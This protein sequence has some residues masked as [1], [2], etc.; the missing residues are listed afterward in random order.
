MIVARHKK[1]RVFMLIIA[2]VMFAATL[3]IGALL[4]GGLKVLAADEIH[5]TH[6]VSFDKGGG[7]GTAEDKIVTRGE[8]YGELP[9][10]TKDGYTFAG[11][12]TLDN[13]RVGAWTEV[14]ATE[15]HFLY[16]KWIP[17]SATGYLFTLSFDRRGGTGTAED[18]IIVFGEAYGTLPVVTKERDTFDGWYTKNGDKITKESIV[19]IGESHYLYARWASDPVWSPGKG[20]NLGA[21]PSGLNWAPWTFG[22]LGVGI[23]IAIIVLLIITGRKHSSAG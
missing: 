5:V 21:G 7:T 12:Y 1:S 13:V 3:S 18:K 11:W 8:P 9:T 15:S 20:P 16:A 22:G 14:T 23:I 17:G 2:A 10:L 6:T 19:I 4:D